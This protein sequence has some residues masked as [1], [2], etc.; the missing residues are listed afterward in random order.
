MGL[1]KELIKG[2]RV[3]GGTM[4]R[5]I[6]GD[7]LV[8]TE[9]PHEMR[10]KPQ[11]FHGR[12][13]LNRYPD[14]MEKCIG[15]QLCA[16]ACPAQCIYVR[17]MD[18]DPDDPTSPG[19]R[20]GYVYEINMLRCIFC[21]LCVE[22]CP[23][24]A[25]TMTSLFEISTTTR[26]DAIYTKRPSSWTG[27][28]TFPTCSPTTNWPISTSWTLP[29]AGC[30]RRRRPVWPHTK[31]CRC[32][33]APRAPPTGH[34]NPH[35]RSGTA[36]QATGKRMVET[37]IFVIAA[38]AALAG[39][40]T[41][42]LARNPIYSAVGLLGTLFSVAILY[43]V[44]L[45][46]LVAAVQVI[47]Y[48]GAVMTLFLFVIML[49]GVDKEEKRVEPL[50]RQRLWVGILAGAVILFAAGRG[51]VRRIRLGSGRGHCNRSGRHQRDD[52]GS[53]RT[54]VHRLGAR[55]RSD[56]PPVDHRRCRR[57]GPGPV[58]EKAGVMVPVGWYMALAAAL[59]LIGALGML[60]RRN[61]LVMFMCIEL[62]LNAVN[63]TLISAGRAMN[64][65]NGQVAVFFILVVAAAEVVVGLAIIV[66]IFRRRATASVD[67][68][69]EL[70]VDE[71][72]IINRGGWWVLS[73]EFCVQ[74]TTHPQDRKPVTK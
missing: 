50:P 19:E 46:H 30:G 29:M 20:F 36:G 38:L 59:F 47:V 16:G 54:A 28:G 14:G 71:L 69:S 2:L 32:G 25:I 17:G 44:Q 70:K 63:L 51:H 68:L 7:E 49:I 13:V 40:V 26:E 64:D 65:L 39:A 27:G 58:Q 1:I 6:A 34:Q 11:R 62:M 18:N 15:C 33:R 57:R 74:L 31:A 10:V 42:V 73:G 45:A 35:R 21:G 52:P 3:T 4:I 72:R 43:V 60:L 56:R 22:A 12:H 5:T 53:C 24:E 61:A 66:A 55:L 9:Y 67:E 48:A 41:V 23:T 37:V 8:T